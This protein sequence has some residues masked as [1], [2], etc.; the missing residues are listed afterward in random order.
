MKDYKR[1][2]NQS[3]SYTSHYP[4][5]FNVEMKKKYQP[6]DPLVQLAI[7]ESAAML[8]RQHHSWKHSLPSPGI[9]VD[10]HDWLWV[11]FFELNGALVRYCFPTVAI[12]AST[13]AD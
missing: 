4:L 2:L 12:P 9:I 7:W 5:A 1:S 10:G 13:F 6:R 8:K 11:L 3:F